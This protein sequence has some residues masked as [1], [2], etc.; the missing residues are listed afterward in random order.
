MNHGA[1]WLRQDDVYDGRVRNDQLEHSLQDVVFCLPPKN[2]I[3]QVCGRGKSRFSQFRSIL[4][5][6]G[7]KKRSEVYFV[8]KIRF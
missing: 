8:R 6:F 1:I 4:T 7:Q 5:N 2:R 3:V